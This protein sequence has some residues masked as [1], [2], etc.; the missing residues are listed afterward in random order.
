MSI[1][2]KVNPLGEKVGR[3]L[4]GN[5]GSAVKGITNIG[6]GI[7]GGLLSQTIGG[8]EDGSGSGLSYPLDVVG[9]AAYPAT[10][11]FK[12]MRY[13]SPTETS[14]KQM[15]KTIEDNKKTSL[16]TNANIDVSNPNE[17][18]ADASLRV[19]GEE[20]EGIRA[21]ISQSLGAITQTNLAKGVSN[22]LKSGMRFLEER[23]QPVVM[24]YF[25]TSFQFVDTAQYD[26]ASIGASGAIGEAAL[27]SGLGVTGAVL[28]NLRSGVNSISDVL[29][30]NADAGEDAMRGA[31]SRINELFGGL[32]GQ[33]IKNAISLQTR[34]IIN[35]NVRSIFRGVALREFSFQF[36]FIANSA[37]E[38]RIVQQ[39]I[40]HF[41][42]QLYPDIFGVTV[43]DQEAAI[44]FKFPNAFKIS[45]QFRGVDS[46]KIPKIK[47]AYLRTL[48]HTI[49]PTGGGFRTDGQ[50]NEIILSMSFV[51]HE[52]ITSKDVSERGF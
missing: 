47:P 19:A 8:Q 3:S 46:S 44:G 12:I 27:Q 35:P 5:V 28:E 11:R 25:P 21:K 37:E 9:N 34:M 2:N 32:A 14:Q 24:L 43:G 6:G 7:D 52:T 15:D 50:P 16:P 36:K 48:T 22:T 10:V 39:I 18:A 20:S 30:S 38:A 40:K 49:N 17:L 23:G 51:E 1:L 31:V 45:F 29:S 41:R 33:G 42:T 26:N 4:F 13:G